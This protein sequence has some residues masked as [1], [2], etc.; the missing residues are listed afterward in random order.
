[1]TG[2]GHEQRFPP[3]GLDVRCRLGQATFIGTDGKGREAPITDLHATAFKL[4]RPTPWGHSHSNQK[5]IIAPA[6]RLL[7][8]RI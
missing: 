5:L 1:M 6:A 4:P 2:M 8:E 7:G 3:L